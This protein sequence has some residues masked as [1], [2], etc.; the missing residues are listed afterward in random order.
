MQNREDRLCRTHIHLD[1]TEC[2]Y[3]IRVDVGARNDLLRR[4]RI[5]IG[6]L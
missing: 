1:Q 3:N 5:S 6:K 4:D 2:Y